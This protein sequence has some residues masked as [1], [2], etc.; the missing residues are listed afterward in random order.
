MRVVIKRERP[1]RSLLLI[2]LA[3]VAAAAVAIHFVHAERELYDIQIAELRKERQRLTK[4]NRRLLEEADTLR[5]S[6]ETAKRSTDIDSRAYAEVNDHLRKLQQELLL[7]KEEVSFYQGIMSDGKGRGVRIHSFLMEP[8]E[9]AGRYRFQLVLTRSSEDDSVLTGTVLLIV[10]G[11]EGGI[12]TRF[13]ISRIGAEKQDA[14][15]F[16]FRHFQRLNGEIALPKEF[17]PSSVEVEALTV[18]KDK[19]VSV[20]ETF[21]W[22]TGPS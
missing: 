3:I 4:D 12:S 1:L 9:E 18:I 13:H 15:Y 22:P 8:A 11:D 7:A 2:C 17:K 10:D 5:R 21:P 20:R 6:V 14:I 19:T 16:R